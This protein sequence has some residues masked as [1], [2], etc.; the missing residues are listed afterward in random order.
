[1]GLRI[2]FASNVIVHSTHIL[3]LQCY[4][5]RITHVSYWL[6]INFI[7]NINLAPSSLGWCV[8]Y[9]CVCMYV[10]IHICMNARIFV[11]VCIYVC[12]GVYVTCTCMY[13]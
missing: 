12:L 2:K 1:M 8:Y 3:Y 5:T 9:V 6:I 10:C 4:M 13:A 7:R 11:C